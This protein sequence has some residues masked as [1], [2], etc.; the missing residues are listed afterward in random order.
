MTFRGPYKDGPGSQNQF[1][2]LVRKVDHTKM[3]HDWSARNKWSSLG[4]RCEC[5]IIMGGYYTSLEERNEKGGDEQC[6]IKT[7]QHIHDRRSTPFL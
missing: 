3:S 7:P 1:S 6:C 2:A 5:N 4:V